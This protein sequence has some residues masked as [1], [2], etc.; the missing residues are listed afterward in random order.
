MLDG[1]A[2]RLAHVGLR[3]RRDGA[4]Q[5]VA[6]VASGGRRQRAAGSGSRGRAGRRAAAAGR[7]GRAGAR[8]PGCRRRRGA[9]R[10]RRGCLRSARRSRPS[11]LPAAEASAW[12]ASSA[13][14]SSCASGPSSSSERRARAPD[15]VGE[16]AHALG[17][18]ELVRAVGRE[19]QNPP[20]VEVVREEDDEIE[21]RGVGPVQVLEHE[22]HGRGGRAIGEQRER[23]LEHA[24]LRARRWPVDRRSSPSGRSASTNGW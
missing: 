19:Q 24:Q 5:R 20:V 18:R 13:V 23:L 17:R 9:L 10:R 3:E 1:P 12:A 22:Q 4:E 2:Q 14:S 6:D 16:S 8:R 7:A 11:A 21:R 15:A